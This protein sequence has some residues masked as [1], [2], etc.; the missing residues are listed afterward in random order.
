MLGMSELK[1]ARRAFLWNYW[2]WCLRLE[3]KQRLI[4]SPILTFP[5]NLEDLWCIVKCP[6]KGWD[7]IVMGF[8]WF[9]YIFGDLCR[10]I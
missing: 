1:L 8:S 3:L 9:K 6:K 4:T 2:D 5:M 7:A 10:E